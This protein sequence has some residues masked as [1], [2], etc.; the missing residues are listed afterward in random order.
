VDVTIA[1][2]LFFEL[3]VEARLEF[4]D[5]A[6]AEAGDV[7]MVAG[8]VCFVIVAV[9]AEVQEIEFVD[10]ALALEEID[11]AVDGDQMNVGIDFLGAVEN[12]VDVKMLLGRIH[13]LK[14]DAALASQTDATVAKRVL[15]MT[16]GGGGVD[17]FAGGNAMCR[18]G[19]HRA[20]PRKMSGHE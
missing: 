1:G 19:R 13:D 2:N 4:T 6:T 11:G 10:E 5:L 18:S 7:D 9:A 17:A 8:A 15:E 16:L 3:L 20:S 12:L 14:D